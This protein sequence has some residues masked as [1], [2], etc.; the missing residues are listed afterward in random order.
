MN[1]CCFGLKN[2][3]DNGK[4]YY[5]DGT[6]KDNNGIIVDGKRMQILSNDEEISIVDIDGDTV[7]ATLK[8]S[9]ANFTLPKD[10][11]Q[12][13]EEITE[14]NQ[15]GWDDID[16]SRV[17]EKSSDYYSLKCSFNGYDV[18]VSGKY[19]A[20]KQEIQLTADGKAEHYGNGYQIYDSN[21]RLVALTFSNFG[22]FTDDKNWVVIE[23]KT[24]SMVI[25][26]YFKSKSINLY[27]KIYND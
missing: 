25:Y 2:A 8:L 24:D 13:N 6:I 26:K 10:A 3:K 14:N 27:Y 19:I 1:L 15:I 12:I 23:Y 22:H 17:N 5:S 18:A 21:F 11:V 9:D 20:I 4:I 16:I 7:H